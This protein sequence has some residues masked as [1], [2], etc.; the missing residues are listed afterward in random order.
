LI[1]GLLGA[2]MAQGLP[3]LILRKAFGVFLMI[4]ATYTIF[5]K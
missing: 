1:G 3:N 4:V 5:A 2:M